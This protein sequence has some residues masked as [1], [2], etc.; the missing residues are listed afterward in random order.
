MANLIYVNPEATLF[1]VP[2][3]AAQAETV[4]F[5]I[6]NL[7][8]GVGRQSA[9]LTTGLGTGARSRLFEWRAF[10]QLDTVTPVLGETIDIYIKTSGSSASATLHPDNDDGT[11]EGALSAED[12]L[13][14]LHYI[15]SIIVDE[16]V[17]NIEFVASGVIEISARAINVVWFNNT[18][19]DITPDVDESGFWLTPAPD[20]VQ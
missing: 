13:K 6:Q 16:A 5:E 14:N 15:G 4:A 1:L 12:K 10:T 11:A 18:V 7:A 3:A 19:S 20:E 9:H 17:V 2:A 8:N